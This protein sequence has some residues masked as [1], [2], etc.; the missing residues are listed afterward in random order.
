MKPIHTLP[1]FFLFI[2]F[3]QTNSILIER[4][5]KNFL[6]QRGINVS[7]EKISNL[8]K[9]IF[10]SVNPSVVY[11]FPSL[12]NFELP[13]TT[14]MCSWYE[15]YY[16][17][18][19]TAITEINSLKIDQGISVLYKEVDGETGIEITHLEKGYNYTPL[20]NNINSN[21]AILKSI[22]DDDKCNF[23]VQLKSPFNNYL[24]SKNDGTVKADSEEK[25]D[26]TKL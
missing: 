15:S 7:P 9:L 19:K 25:D 16:E 23:Y 18:F 4:K 21:K 10:V 3:F 6:D 1:L 22:I 5:L 8:D 13:A 17:K 20:K 12:L 26:C 11:T 2:I 24:C 14:E